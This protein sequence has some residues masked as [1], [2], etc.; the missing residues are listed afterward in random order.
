MNRPRDQLL[1]GPGLTK[2]Q[3]G[4][5]GRSDGFHLLQHRLQAVAFADDFL[6]V[7]LGAQLLLEIA[8][9]LFE[10]AAELDNSAKA[11]VDLDDPGDLAGRLEKR[12]GLV[13][14]EST[15]CRLPTNRVPITSPRQFRGTQQP[16][17]IPALSWW[18][19]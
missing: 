13:L 10:L 16:D 12:L 15:S 17:L 6:E 9:F 1:S 19:G 2:D 4:C 14:V 7:V 11:V 3:H 8:L 5:G 18:A